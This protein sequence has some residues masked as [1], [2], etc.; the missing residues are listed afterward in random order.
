MNKYAAKVRYGKREDTAQRKG[1]KALF[2]V[3][4]AHD[5]GAAYSEFG[6]GT[7]E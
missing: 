7:N 5:I 4:Y 6:C 3:L 2:N 1:E